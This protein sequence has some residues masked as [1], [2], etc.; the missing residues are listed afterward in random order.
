MKKQDELGNHWPCFLILFIL[1]IFLN[2][3]DPYLASI[4]PVFSLC[5]FYTNPYVDTEGEVPKK[6]QFF[7]DVDFI[8]EGENDQV[9]VLN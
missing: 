8:P 4:Y 1:L 7:I 2:L 5:Y 9:Q 6:I 3:S